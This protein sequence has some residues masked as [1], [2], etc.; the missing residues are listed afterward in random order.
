MTEIIPFGAEARLDWLG[1]TEALAAGHRLPR[2]QVADSFL[3]RA[4]DTL[5]TR[6]ALID[7][8]GMAVKAATI[9]PH[10]QG[11]TV[12]GGV[13]LLDDTT[14]VMEAIVDFH[15]VTKW[16]TA[17]DS[18]LAARHLAPDNPETILIVG[19]GNVAASLREAYGAG[20]PG[21]RFLVW[22]RSGAGDF[23]ARH[24][25]TTAVT[26]LAQAVAQAD[27]VT[28]ATTAKTPILRGDWLRPGQHVDLIGAFRADMREAD[29]RALTRARIF[30]DSRDTTMHHIGE[31]KIPL[32]AGVIAPGDILGDF[33][34]LAGGGFARQPEDITLF[35]N[36]GGAH[37]DLM[38]ARYI[39]ECWRA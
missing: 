27:I 6:S 21:A 4:D 15:L 38:T 7:G 23:A 37:L 22:N 39:L 11:P 1:L 8:L 18:L 9:F 24:P 34:D 19:T 31:I 5:L 10:N 30:V 26:D 13:M 25:D 17:A 12:N 16:K 14:G 36:G 28:S 29:D 35:K 33:Y 2:A 20:F 3:K 32:E